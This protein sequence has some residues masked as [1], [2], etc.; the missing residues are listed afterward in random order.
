MLAV[1]QL[2]LPFFQR[3][4]LFL[5]VQFTFGQLFGQNGLLLSQLLVMC[6]RLQLFAL[7]PLLQ[8]LPVADLLFQPRQALAQQRSLVVNL[9]GLFL[10]LVFS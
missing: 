7:Q 9:M 4:L 2:Q 8:I 10:L 3:Q 6:L 1:F 5:Q